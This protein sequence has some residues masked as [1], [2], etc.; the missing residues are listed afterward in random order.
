[1]ST[2]ILI[3]A[4][5]VVCYDAISNQV[6][7]KQTTELLELLRNNEIEVRKSEQGEDVPTPNDRK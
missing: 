4:L 3:L 2:A 1:M 5:V 7:R 6:Y